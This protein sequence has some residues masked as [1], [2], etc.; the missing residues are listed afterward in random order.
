ML[1]LIKLC[2]YYFTRAKAASIIS[3][4]FDIC[5]LSNFSF[6]A[7]S[8]NISS[9]AGLSRITVQCFWKRPNLFSACHKAK[10]VSQA[11]LSHNFCPFELGFRQSK[12]WSSKRLRKHR[13]SPILLGSK[14]SPTFLC[15]VNLQPILFWCSSFLAK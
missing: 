12:R 14:K 6:L 9:H 4:I 13:A 11:I 8:R 5:L 2:S 1:H 15:F 3:Q 7:S 10:K